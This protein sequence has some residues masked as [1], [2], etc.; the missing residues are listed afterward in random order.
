MDTKLL[1]PKK[2]GDKIF[3]KRELRDSANFNH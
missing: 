2:T 1:C 3:V